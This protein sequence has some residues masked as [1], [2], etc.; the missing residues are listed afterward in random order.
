MGE[1][2][3]SESKNELICNLNE[4]VEKLSSISNN[5]IS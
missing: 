5:K 4:V 3:S 1:K 2:I